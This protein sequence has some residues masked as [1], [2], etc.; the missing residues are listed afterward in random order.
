M[1][2]GTADTGMDRIE[3]LQRGRRRVAIG[4]ARPAA[5]HRDPGP[6]MLQERCARCGGAAVMRHLQHLPAAAVLRQR[7]QQVEVPVFLEVAG[8]QRPLPS[9]P[10]R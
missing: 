10:D 5:D 1:Q 8:Q 4:I 3:A 6:E 9:E 7:R 2:I